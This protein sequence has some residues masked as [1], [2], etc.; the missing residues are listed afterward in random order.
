M[1]KKDLIK[2]VIDKTGL[3]V[4]EADKTIDALLLSIVELTEGG[5]LLTLKWF[6]RFRR[7]TRTI[8]AKLPRLKDIAIAKTSSNL[9]FVG[10]NVLKIKTY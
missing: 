4:R 8:S 1:N 3:T 2:K 5:D 9:T 7:K 6:G 10:S